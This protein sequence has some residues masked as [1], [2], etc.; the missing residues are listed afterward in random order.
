ML[1]YCTPGNKLFR[2]NIVAR[3]QREK[4]PSGHYRCSPPRFSL[5]AVYIG[6]RG[7]VNGLK[8]ARWSRDLLFLRTDKSR[9][10]LA[11]RTNRYFATRRFARRINRRRNRSGSRR[12]LFKDSG[13]SISGRPAAAERRESIS[14]TLIHD[15]RVRVGRTAGFNSH[16]SSTRISGEITSS[17]AARI[18]R[19]SEGIVL[20]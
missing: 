3:G 11:P 14:R 5:I 9:G 16:V 7:Q 12:R 6:R 13:S 1:Q 4:E 17:V 20:R 18:A 2:S 19:Y 10:C 8:R 15:F